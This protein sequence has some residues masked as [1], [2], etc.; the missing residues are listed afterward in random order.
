MHPDT[1]TGN[2]LLATHKLYNNDRS[3]TVIIPVIST[4]ISFW[5]PGTKK[6]LGSNWDTCTCM[7]GPRGM[8]NSM[9][10]RK[11]L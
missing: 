8:H 6:L 9:A 10:V 2:Q 1:F 7:H 4:T 5:F 11:G 3:Y